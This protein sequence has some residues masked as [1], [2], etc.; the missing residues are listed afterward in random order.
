M[1]KSKIHQVHVSVFFRSSLSCLPVEDKPTPKTQTTMATKINREALRQRIKTLAGL[2]DDERAALLELVNSKKYG[3]VWENH[4]EEVEERL[5]THLPVLD[6]VPERYIPGSSPSSPNHILIE[7]DNLEALTALTYTHEGRI[8]VI[9][10]D[11]PY[12]TGNRDFVYN[13][14]YID[15]DD[16]YRH[17][18]WLSF[19]SKRLRIAKRLLSD[20][21]V[22]F[23]SVDDNEQASLKILC[24]DIMGEGNYEGFVWKKKGG[25]GNTERILGCLTEYILCFF[26]K[27]KAGVFRYRDIK[28]EYKYSD[29]KG[30]YNLEGIE[31]TN[32]GIY[33]RPTMLFPIIDP[34]TGKHFYPKKGMRWTIGES[35]VYQAISKEKLYFNYEKGKVYYKKRDEDYQK[36][37]NVFYNLLLEH[38]SLA[39][40]KDEL[41]S[42]LGDRELFDT[43]KPLS[44][45]SHLI[46]IASTKTSIILDF[47][48]GSGT[49]MHAVMQLNKEDGGH[50]QCILVTN[51]ENKICEEVT[52]K[53]NKRV[54]EGYT[55]PKGVEVEGLRDNS[56]RYYRTRLLPR[57]RTN[58]N[59]RDLMAAATD[60]LC[61]KE[62]IFEELRIQNLE[63]RNIRK[64]VR[65][66]GKGDRLMMVIYSEEAIPR[67][68]EWLKTTPPLP[69]SEGW[70]KAGVCSNPIKIY[71]F[72][73]TNYAYDDDFAEV[74]D[75]VQLC[76]LPA[77]IYEAYRRVLP[78]ENRYYDNEIIDGSDADEGKEDNQ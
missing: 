49:T 68:V 16:D 27:K 61:I 44:L 2:S 55:T 77:A 24:D 56:L 70:P 12:N 7:G 73:Y 54:I 33:E 65:L 64:H 19:M 39:V 14:K 8:D 67:I 46:F 37:E 52:Y 47:F 60:L 29:E 32:S 71:T 76:A 69:S 45:L 5:R 53:R 11:P 48:A 26:K 4:P 1:D 59:M 15:A 18:K 36:S 66:F 72:S 6:E 17:S 38:G 78:Q 57:Q 22:I 74:E 58:R 9:Y 62:D 31:K 23:I 42:V 20:R 40:A 41:E 30:G 43:P 28:R 51:N 25:A 13:D 75:R 21:G 3:L 63:I 35:S 10:I 34:K 50:R